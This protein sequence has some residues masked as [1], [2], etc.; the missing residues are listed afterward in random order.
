LIAAKSW[1][2][3]HA[4]NR[5]IHDMIEM[6]TFR[7]PLSNFTSVDDRTCDVIAGGWGGF[8]GDRYTLKAGDLKEDQSEQRASLVSGQ[9]GTSRL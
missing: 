7:T 9:S 2:K 1:Q 3:F 8:A 6:R 5:Q 4:I